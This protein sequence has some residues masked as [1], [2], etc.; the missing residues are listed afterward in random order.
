MK[1]NYFFISSNI[2]DI[3]LCKFQGEE[4]GP[5]RMQQTE[6]SIDPDEIPNNDD[7]HSANCHVS[8]SGEPGKLSDVTTASGRFVKLSVNSNR[9]LCLHSSGCTFCL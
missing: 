5:D 1:N 4:G 6:Q 2:G 8:N 7:P 9:N 3:K